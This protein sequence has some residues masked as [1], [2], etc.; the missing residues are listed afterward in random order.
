MDVY[1]N[2]SDNK[3][4]SICMKNGNYTYYPDNKNPLDSSELQPWMTVDVL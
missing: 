3:S 1:G 2:I 4:E